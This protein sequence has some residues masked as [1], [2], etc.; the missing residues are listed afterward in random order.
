MP[1]LNP[2]D[3]DHSAHSFLDPFR[4]RI[5]TPVADEAAVRARLDGLT[6]PP[7][8]LGEL[9]V[10]ALRL[11]LVLGDPP[12]PLRRR[13]VLIFAADHGVARRGVSAYPPEVTA[14]MCRNFVAGG[15]AINA[16]ARSVGAEVGVIDAGV[17]A[18]SG[19]LPGVIDRKVRR[20]S[21]DLAEGPA[22]TASEVAEAMRH[23]FDAARHA[24]ADVLALGD[25]GIGNTTAA[26]A[27]TA[28]LTNAPVETLVGPGTGIDSAAL[29]LKRDIVARSAARVS[30]ESTVA[31][32][33][34]EVGGLEIAAI[35]GATLGAAAA[36][37][38]VIADGFIVTAGVLAAVRIEPAV[39]RYVFA[40]HCSAEPGHHVQLQALGLRPLFDLGLRL[41]EGTGAALAM[42]VL[43][44]AGA[45][46]REMATFEQ[47]EVSTRVE[48][49][50]A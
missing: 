9:E 50:D 48:P 20:G 32:I 3:A 15:A 1:P 11:A 28:A 40:S 44:A 7:G 13:Q 19:A 30:P 2:V 47:A 49:A 35:A 10:I 23:G 8:S 22:L 33:L 16:I 21:R 37:I 17:D 5:G 38:P 42:P 26:A 27:V 4:D 6:K 31:E 14:Q 45:V 29:A 41:G 36:G 18:A 43:D 12:P 24:A 39:R 25:M 34:A 46:L